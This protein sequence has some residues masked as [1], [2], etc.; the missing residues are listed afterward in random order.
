MTK[1]RVSENSNLERFEKDLN[2][3]VND[4]VILLK[5]TENENSFAKFKDNYEIWYS[6]SLYVIEVLLPKRKDDFISYYNNTKSR[7]IRELINPIE[8]DELT[9]WGYDENASINN[10]K[11]L[12][13]NQLN[14]LKSAKN[15]LSSTL[16]EIK[17]ILQADLYK[18]ELE[19]SSELNKKG[20]T[21]GAG[22]IAG[23][24]LE[25]HLFQVCNN[26]NIKLPRKNLSIN[27]YNQLLKDNEIIDI[28]GWRFIQFLADIRNLCDHK[29]EKEPTK[30]DIDELIKGT[31]KI[32]KTIY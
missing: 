14:I 13:T 25:S 12:F 7:C 2:K 3:L 23:V 26:H 1:D 9:N 19:T 29:K 20:F 32:C 24:V 28:K 4:G 5:S 8:K 6:E 21:R 27:D 17:H 30:E 16:F 10:T 22:A 11:T 15:R 31:D 18:N